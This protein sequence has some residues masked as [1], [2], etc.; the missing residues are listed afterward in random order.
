MV[1]ILISVPEGQ[2]TGI[3]T[4]CYDGPK[5]VGLV[6]FF[7]EQKQNLRLTAIE[8]RFPTVVRN[9]LVWALGL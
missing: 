6:Y 5:W 9:L 8:N 4:Y 7:F 2:L 3:L 1:L